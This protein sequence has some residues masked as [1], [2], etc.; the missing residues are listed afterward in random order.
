LIEGL[1]K[2]PEAFSVEF[3][4]VRDV[5]SDTEELLVG[6]TKDDTADITVAFHFPDSLGKSVYDFQVQS[7]GDDSVELHQRNM[8]SVLDGNHLVF[9]H[10]LSLQSTD[11]VA[12]V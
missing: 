5:E 3:E 7:V 6:A 10:F 9:N 2:A 4:Q 11:G 8:T 12:T 1:K